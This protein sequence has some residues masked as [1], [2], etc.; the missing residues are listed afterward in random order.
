M[1]RQVRILRGQKKPASLKR[2]A[3]CDMKRVC[4][5]VYTVKMEPVSSVYS[6]GEF[7]TPPLG[8]YEGY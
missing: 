5:P 4:L 2:E 3:G 7:N 6:C 8:A 1:Q